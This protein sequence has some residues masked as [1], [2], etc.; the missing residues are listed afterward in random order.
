MNRRSFA[1]FQTGKAHLGLLKVV[2]V[3]KASFASDCDGTRPQ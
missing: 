2:V 3:S 1:E